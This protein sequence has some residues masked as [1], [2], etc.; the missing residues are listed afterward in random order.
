MEIETDSRGRGQILVKPPQGPKFAQPHDYK[1]NINI[2]SV[3]HLV[4]AS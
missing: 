1:P 4:S 3:A 2:K